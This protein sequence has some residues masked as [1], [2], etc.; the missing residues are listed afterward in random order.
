MS[1]QKKILVIVEG[2]KTEQQFFKSLE[3]A[4]S[5]NFT[6]CCFRANIFTLYSKLEELDFNA[7]IKQVL[8]EMHPEYKETLSDKFAYTYLIF[9]FDAHHPK[10]EDVRSL[11]EISDMREL[12]DML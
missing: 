2:E 3:S 11:E 10:R 5:F 6:I 1:N 12:A 8:I 4:F 9:D 7:D